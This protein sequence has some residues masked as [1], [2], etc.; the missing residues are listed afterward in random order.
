MI[1]S[2]WQLLPAR[3]RAFWGAQNVL[4]V[5]SGVEEQ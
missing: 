5:M 3:S 4:A 2:V 1:Y